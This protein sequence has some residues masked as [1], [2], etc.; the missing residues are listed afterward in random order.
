M[1]TRPNKVYSAEYFTRE[2]EGARYYMAAKNLEAVWLF[3][4]LR[5]GIARGTGVEAKALAA[6]FAA[7]DASGATLLHNTGGVAKRVAALELSV[8]APKTVSMVWA[9]GT[10]S[11][12]ADVETAFFRSLQA[13]AD[14]VEQNTFARLGRGGATLVAVKPTIAAF[15]Q[16]DTRPVQLPDGTLGIQPQLHAH[17]VIPNCVSCPDGKV[18][19]LDATPLYRGAK[20]WGALQHLVL[21]T[22]LQTLGYQIGE[23]GENGTFEIVAPPAEREADRSLRSFWS[24]RRGAVVAKLAAVGLTTR[25]APA[26][27]A[28]AAVA[29]RRK[30]VSETRDVFK[31]WREEAVT[32]G[33]ATER[34]VKDR[35]T[36][37]A[38]SVERR[39]AMIAER[40]AAI[41][42]RLTEHEATFCH[43]DLLREVASALVGTGADAARVEVE[44]ARLRNTQAI[45]ALGETQRERMF[46]TPE[47]RRIERDVLA[48][49]QRLSQRPWRSIDERRLAA[50]C[51]A[52][53]LSVEQ[54]QAATAITS[55]RALTF[56]EGRAGTGKTTLLRPVCR[57]F[58][59]EVRVIGAATAWRTAKLLTEELGIES[60]A[61]DK[62]LAD[63][64]A[65]QRFLDRSTVVL[66][67][68]ASQIG[69]R[70][71]DALLREVESSGAAIVVLGDR[72][73]TLPVA[74]GFG[75]DVVARATAPALVSRVVR[76]RNTTLRLVVEGLARG[77]VKL[78]VET[79]FNEGA[80]HEA[81]GFKAAVVDAVDRWMGSDR[82]LPSR[83]TLLI[84]RTN[85]NRFA[86]D[87][88]VRARLRESGQLTGPEVVVNAVTASGNP[89]KLILATGDR[90]R[91]GVRADI[92]DGVING[93][94]GTIQAITP[95]NNGHAR[96]AAVVEGRKVDFSTRDVVDRSGHVR[97]GTDYATTVFSAQGLTCDRAVILA[98]LGYDR[99]DLYVAVSR[100]REGVDLV[101]DSEPITLGIRAEEGFVRSDDKIAVSERADYLAARMSRAHVKTSTLDLL[102]H[103]E[104]RLA[105]LRRQTELDHEL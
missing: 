16:P 102:P 84:A 100:A 61:L 1:V 67:D 56:L 43:H 8:G 101:V 72:G 21:A 32:H 2:V 95:Q 22:E 65:G 9:L 54:T 96:V 71:M 66:V 74:A 17:L 31:R 85:T 80:I 79:L 60:K 105:E 63:A 12:R 15:M 73:Q 33:V 55:G 81:S 64:R 30:K 7:Q 78:A 42:A 99:R 25:E 70:A 83:D 104:G 19:S 57:A 103:A 88:E 45:V 51:R 34:Y 23:I 24:Q 75:L 6:L 38:L 52:A 68:E 41:P 97:L 20:S 69:L 40:L 11:Q 91:F 98:D 82:S 26:L 36:A 53:G 77:E 39:E 62:W 58:A 13:V 27:A 86:L 48:S 76:Q 87:A 90:I 10:E 35:Q 46:T 4:D 3:G 89:Y 29:T 44:I 37:A 59:P 93:T 5:L 18:R 14:Q 92:G 49:A 94:T 50:N 28:K 47:M